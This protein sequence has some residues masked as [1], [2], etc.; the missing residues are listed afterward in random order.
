[1]AS[2]YRRKYN[3][4]TPDGRWIEKQC[5][6]Y[7]IE[8]RHP[9]T[10]KQVRIRGFKDKGA[11][12]QKAAELERAVARGATGLVDPFASHKARA[13][14]E[15]VADWL[16]DLR[17]SGRSHMYVYTCE[18][19]MR[20]LCERASWARLTDIESNSF[21]RW[22]AAYRA[23]RSA[24]R[25]RGGTGP[26]ARTLN[27]FLETARAFC[28]WCESQKRIALNPLRLVEKAEGPVARKRRA[29]SDEQ[30]TAL[31]AAAPPER[32]IVYRVALSIGL[33]RSELEQLQWGDLGLRA[34][35]PYVQLRAEAT[36]A[37]R[38]DRLPLPQPIADEL[39]TIRP[40]DAGDADHVFRPV[41][42]LHWWRRDLAAAGIPWKDDQGRQVDFHAGTRKTL[43]TR[44][45]RA[46]VPLAIAMR[47]MRHTDAKLTMVDYVD[48]GQ[49]DMD[50]AIRN[51]PDLT[52]VKTVSKS[53]TAAVV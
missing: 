19:R 21:I 17:A 39:R 16:A 31:L 42:S 14:T 22:R 29:L 33:R 18:L 40:D 48:D 43:C 34:I 24:G 41:P 26:S 38:G 47:V 52:P 6:H 36:K 51:L 10:G 11:T 2:V 3:V 53:P 44:L 23:D 4:Q 15:H 32:A 49:L 50:Q 25:G 9:E 12:L 37:R 1:M 27:Q 20:I 28:N 46:G 5:R 7:V 35:K 8:Y 13:L 45:H 30:A